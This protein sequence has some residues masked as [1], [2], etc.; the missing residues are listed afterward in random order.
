MGPKLPT[1]LR[2]A[3]RH[4]R[5]IEPAPALLEAVHLALGK[6]E[7]PLLVGGA[8]GAGIR[9]RVSTLAHGAVLGRTRRRQHVER[10]VVQVQRALPAAAGADVVEVLGAVGVGLA[11]FAAHGGAE[12]RGFVHALQ[13]LLGPAGAGE[14]ELVR[15]VEAELVGVEDDVLVHV[16]EEVVERVG[17]LELALPVLEA[18]EAVAE[19]DDGGDFVFADVLDGGGG[20]VEHA[21]GVEVGH[22]GFVAESVHCY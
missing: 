12:A 13:R 20:P 17:V 21:V 19:D 2:R 18:H 3:L 7:Q 9:V 1:P 6:L 14:V 15:V 22:A 8:V 11:P 10:V 4:P 16:Q 5:P